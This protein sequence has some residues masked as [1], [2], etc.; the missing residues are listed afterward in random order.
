MKDETR[1]WLRHLGK[2]AGE[3]PCQPSEN[4]IVAL[5]H[6]SVEPVGQH[7]VKQ[8]CADLHFRPMGDTEF[9]A[10]VELFIFSLFVLGAVA[11]EGC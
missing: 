1:A 7:D 6:K 9:A 8:I 10:E 4:A 11:E 2:R 3:L 5:A